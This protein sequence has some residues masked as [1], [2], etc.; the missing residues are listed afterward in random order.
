MT[1]TEKP[2]ELEAEGVRAASDRRDGL[3]TR[4]LLRQLAGIAHGRLTMVM[5]DG[6][7]IGFGEPNSAPSVTVTVHHRRTA[8]RLA[9]G[10]SLGFA[11]A[12]MEGDWEC[13][14][15]TQLILLAIANERQLGLD[16]D[17]I[18]AVRMMNR[19]WHFLHRNSRRGSRRNIAY[20]YDLGNEFYG[21]WLDPSMTYSSALFETPEQDLRA[22]QGAKNRQ[23]AAL[24][25]LAAGQRV[26]EIGCGWGGFA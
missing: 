1:M 3:W 26:L 9:L 6:R 25:G 17:G 22:A 14:D 24:L 16:K 10:G 20:H 5:P 21:Q 23:V 8:R 12:F 7:V 4:L 13:S 2:A 18:W 15:L 11:E 19:V